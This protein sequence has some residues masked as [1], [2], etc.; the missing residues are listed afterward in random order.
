MSWIGFKDTNGSCFDTGGLST[1]MA[2]KIGSKTGDSLREQRR[3]SIWVEAIYDT[4]GIDQALAFCEDKTS[5]S[6]IAVGITAAGTF[7]IRLGKHDRSER[8]DLPTSIMPG[9]HRIRISFSWSVDANWGQFSIF[10]P[11]SD[12]IF[13]RFVAVPNGVSVGALRTLLTDDEN[14][15]IADNVVF[16]A[17]SDKVE[18]IGPL[19]NLAGSSQITTPAGQTSLSSLRRGDLVTTLDGETAQVRWVGSTL[20]PA[21]GSLR[22]I[23]LRAP[24][25][26]LNKDCFV[27][28]NQRLLQTGAE[29][30]YLFG[31]EDVL[32]KTRDL[33]NGSSTLY[34]KAPDVVRYYH[35]LLDRHDI[36]NVNGAWMESF[37]AL[38]VLDDAVARESSV[39][40]ELP[41]ELL[42]NTSELARPVLQSFETVT[43]TSLKVA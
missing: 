28:G 22:P 20:V 29:V 25:H 7:W 13:H 26:N 18:P 27:S 42:P 19:P 38:P 33:L 40:S 24:Y 43:L 10:V 11:Q 3:G 17:V 35:L 30:E 31:E 1:T 14:S 16:M 23:C 4:T 12:Q 9:R 8:Y 41:Y 15:L 37:H 2:R 34:A 6:G 21:K 39:I 32:T 5:S 36:V